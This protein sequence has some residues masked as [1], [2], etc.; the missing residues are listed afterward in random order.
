MIMEF[1]GSV[2][3]HP[4]TEAVADIIVI[5][6]ALR[7]LAHTWGWWRLPFGGEGK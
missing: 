5:Y 7:A 2:W 6:Y 3:N 1:L 4:I